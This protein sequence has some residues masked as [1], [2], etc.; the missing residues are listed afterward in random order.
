MLIKSAFPGFFFLPF[1]RKIE[2]NR[3]KFCAIT[4][5]VTAIPGDYMASVIRRRSSSATD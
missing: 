4:A 5:T 1:L 2:L 3:K